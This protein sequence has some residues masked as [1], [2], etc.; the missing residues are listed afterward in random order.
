[1]KILIAGGGGYIGSRVS[2]YLARHGH[3]I[4]V[5]DAFW[6]GNHLHKSEPVVDSIKK[7]I[8]EIDEHLLKG[9]DQ[10]IFMAGLSNDPMAEYSPGKN[11]IFNAAAPAY[12]AYLARN[13]GV[14][15]FIYA[16]SCSVYGFT[17]GREITEEFRPYSQYPYSVSKLQGG[18]AV[19]QLQDDKFSVIC[20]RQGTVSGF[21]PR[22]RLDLIVNTMHMKALKD[23]KITINNPNI[24]RPILAMSDAEEVYLQ[25][26]GAPYEL[27]G[28]FNVCS[29]NF[30]VGEVADIVEKHF[31]KKHG[32]KIQKEIKNIKD[33]RNYRV[34][35]KKARDVLGIKF[36]GSVKS[37]LDELDEH[38]GKDFDFEN[39]NYYNI[40]VF[41]TLL[42]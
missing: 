11:F 17:D 10:V 25:T 2:P 36:M 8:F 16:D 30:T 39:K 42:S 7:D 13:S 27:S 1:M 15:R 12:L 38:I 19:M 3:E 32:T 37:I 4:T 6:F 21:S 9:F 34:S 22:M 28:V 24:W 20:L 23:G 14:R 5:L 33:Y 40:E 35:N 41:K 31:A 29:K 26:I 18:A